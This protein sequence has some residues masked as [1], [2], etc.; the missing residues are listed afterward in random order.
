MFWQDQEDEKQQFVVP[1]NVV[2]LSFKV[3]CKELPLDHAH[4]LSQTIQQALPWFAD[5]SLAGMHLIHGAES[6]NGWIRPQEPDAIL[7]LSK[8]TRFMLRLP[9]H[10]VEDA[11][12]LAGQELNV[13][14]NRLILS[15]PNQK[16]LS[17]LTTIFARYVVIQGM[18]DSLEDEEAFLNQAAE[19]L[20]KEGIQ[21]KKMM[22]GRMHVLQ[23]PGKDLFT[24]SLMIDGLKIEESIYLQ[25]H[26]LGDGRLVGCGLFM[27][28]K[29]IE[30]VGEAQQK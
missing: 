24:R 5:E 14:G 11:S 26:G 3:Q 8:R 2:D 6:G 19:M 15:T 10:R 23:M 21:V 13:A 1:E 22:S 29:G 4:A 20:R 12:K 7:S 30:A 9:K 18:E 28:H 27:P 25:Q 17:V 16:P